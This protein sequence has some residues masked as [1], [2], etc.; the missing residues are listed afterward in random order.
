MNT[1]QVPYNGTHHG[2]TPAVQHCCKGLCLEEPSSWLPYTFIFFL[3]SVMNTSFQ[4][5]PLALQFSRSHL[6]LWLS[7]DCLT[8]CCWLCVRPGVW[9]TLIR[10]WCPLKLH[11]FVNKAFC[12]SR[13]FFSYRSD[14]EKALA[15]TCGGQH[16]HWDFL[17]VIQKQQNQ[18]IHE[19]QTIRHSMCCWGAQITPGACWCL[20]MVM[21]RCTDNSKAVIAMEESLTLVSHKGI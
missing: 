3:S 5:F 20:I 18:L 11:C 10:V 14:D 7:Q 17:L 8:S 16:L 1:L 13:G 21:W 4:P 19:R 12:S 2:L 6:A 9:E 15:D